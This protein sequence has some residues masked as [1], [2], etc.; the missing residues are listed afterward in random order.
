MSADANGRRHVVVVGGGF[1]GVGCARRAGQARR[2]ARHADRPQQLPPV[3]AAA[4]PGGDV[5]ARAE[6]HRATRC[7]SCSPTT[8]TSTSSSRRSRRSTRRRRPSRPTDG[9]RVAGDALVLAAGSQPNFFRTPGAEEHAFPLY[10]LDDAQRLRSRILGVFEEADRDP[11]ADRPG[12]AE[13]RRR[14]R[15]ADR[16]RARR[17]ARRPDPRDDDRRV[18]RPR[19]HGRADAH[20]RP[21]PHAARRRS[22]T[23]RTTT[24]RR[25]SAARAC[26]CTSAWRS[27][28]SGPGTSTL[29]DGTTIRTPLRRLGRRHHGARRSPPA[30]GLPQGRG[31]R[32]D[33]QPDLTRRRRAR[34]LRRRRRRQHPGPGRATPPAARLGR[35]AE[36]RVG[37]RQHPRRLR[38]QAAQAAST[39]TTR[40]SW[41]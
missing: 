41:R 11:R 30:A 37:G 40:A 18:P 31:G 9:E 21:R 1:A 5:A 22:P 34:R 33:V 35:A 8:R 27:P 10:S 15:R 23:A 7:A 3:P 36:R 2:R 24:W 16:R 19:R 25:C 13:L 38:G 4:L 6:R 17:R 12:R 39:T 14:R 20:R 28:R 29:A 32:I 26:G